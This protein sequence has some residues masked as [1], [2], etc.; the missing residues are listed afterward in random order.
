LKV[1]PGTK[2]N[3]DKRKEGKQTKLGCVLSCA[4][5]GNWGMKGTISA[6]QATEKGNSL[7][8]RTFLFKERLFALGNK[9]GK[10]KKGRHEKL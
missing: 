3:W 6:G 4:Q 1:V 9:G 2:P 10:E 7:E 8:K 5:Q